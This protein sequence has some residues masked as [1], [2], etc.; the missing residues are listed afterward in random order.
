MRMWRLSGILKKSIWSHEYTT[1]ARNPEQVNLVKWVYDDFQE[2]LTGQ[3]GQMS[4]SQLT[5]TPK[6]QS[7]QMSIQRPTGPLKSEPG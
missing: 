5:G 2:P 6:S 4:I 7:G 1:I 3:S